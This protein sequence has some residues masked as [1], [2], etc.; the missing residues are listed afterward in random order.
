[1]LICNQEKN[2]IQFSPLLIIGQRGISCLTWRPCG[3]AELAV[4]CKMG[5]MLW[6]LDPASVVSR[7]STSCVRTLS[8]PGHSPV[9]SLAWHSS[10]RLLASASP[11][12]SNMLIW[13]VASEQCL[14]VKRVSGGGVSLLRWSADGGKLFAAT[15]GRTFR[16]WDTKSWLPER[17]S[18]PGAKVFIVN[19]FN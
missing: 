11:S 10:G 18:V 17:W 16:V 1:M 9:T 2:V 8:Q 4:G 6:T 13:S 12:D 14:P 7:P 15:P 3:T 19:Y 5:I